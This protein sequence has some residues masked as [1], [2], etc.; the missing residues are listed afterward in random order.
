MVGTVQT[1][2][3][4]GLVATASET[5]AKRQ[6]LADSP[7]GTASVQ[8]APSTKIILPPLG[9]PLSMMTQP[10]WPNSEQL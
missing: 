6:P 9:S 10:S 7:L 1:P 5:E 4:E 3:K 2:L 8:K